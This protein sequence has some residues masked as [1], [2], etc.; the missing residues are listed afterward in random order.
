VHPAP[1]PAAGADA[2]PD[3]VRAVT[4]ADLA[5][6]VNADYGPGTLLGVRGWLA[7]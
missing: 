7:G 3:G 6:A 1:A 2:A 5:R 4:I